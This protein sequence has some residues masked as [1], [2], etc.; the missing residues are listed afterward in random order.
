MDGKYF[1]VMA[2]LLST[3]VSTWNDRYLAFATPGK[4]LFACLF[5]FRH[6]FVGGSKQI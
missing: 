5:V 1:I 6:G 4:Q 3:H 2:L